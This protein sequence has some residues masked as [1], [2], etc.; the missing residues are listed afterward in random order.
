MKLVQVEA[1]KIQQQ[2]EIEK[3]VKKLQ[4]EKKGWF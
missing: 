3:K 4:N 1:K 2:D